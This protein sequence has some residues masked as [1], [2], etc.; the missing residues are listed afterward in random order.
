MFCELSVPPANS[1]LSDYVE[2]YFNNGCMVGVFCDVC[3]N[4]V[5]VEKSSR[6]TSIRDTE[7]FTV[8]LTRAQE[9]LDGFGFVRNEVVSTNDV[10]IR[11]T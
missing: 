2:E 8:I 5:Q 3:K 7:F 6:L 10:C 11:Y 9:T 1:S 4:L